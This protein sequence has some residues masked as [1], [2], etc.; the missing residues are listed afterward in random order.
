MELDA[1]KQSILESII[2]DY[3]ATA[4]PVGS[5]AIARNHALKVSAATVRNEMSDLEQMGYLEQPHT[6]AGRIPSEQGLRYYVDCMM[7]SERLSDQETAQL[8]RALHSKMQDIEDVVQSVGQ[9]VAE[10]TKYVS[11][12]VIPAMQMNRIVNIQFYQLREGLGLLVI[13]TDTGGLLYEKL[14]VP[15]GMTDHDLQ[16]LGSAFRQVLAGSRLHAIRLTDLQL[17]REQIGKHRGF[18]DC[19]LETLENMQDN[20][21]EEKVL[22]SGVLNMLDAPE[23]K[24]ID[25]LRYLLALFEGKE[26]MKQLLPEET[27][28]AVDIR[29]GRENTVE[30]SYPFSLVFSSF[31]TSGDKGKIGLLGPVRMEYWKATGIID[32]V[33]VVMNELFGVEPD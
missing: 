9:Y 21:R 28:C 7:K 26:T 15:P 3:V 23:F 30:E 17:L 5:R 32:S 29:I 18:L 19:V 33:R 12:V 31:K 24:N 13:L 14:L 25:K 16:S 11:F 1:R 10:R 20:D 22:L 6:S 27:K 2:R 8:S 4:E